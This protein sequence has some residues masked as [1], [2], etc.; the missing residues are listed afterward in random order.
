M[1][2]QVRRA[3]PN[4]APAYA[5]IMGDPAVYPGL[6]Q[7]PHT[8][9]E[10]WRVRLTETCAPGKQ[11][12]PLVAE[13]NGEVVGNAGLHPVGVAMR[14]RHVMALGIAVA[15]KAQG[16]GVGSALMQ[17]M[18]DYADR[19]VGVLR[20]ELSVYTDN[21]V[22][23][24]LYRK[25]GFVIEGTMRGFSLRDGRYVDTHAMA[26]FHPDPPAI[27]AFDAHQPLV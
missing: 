24:R 20:L 26:R 22:A 10:S 21:A 9:E 5:A 1:T 19:W 8:D 4:D 2:I 7:M 18:C 13:L 15:P 17:A 6:L 23:L 14:R 3:S 27:T 12:L 25:F 11:D 16:Q